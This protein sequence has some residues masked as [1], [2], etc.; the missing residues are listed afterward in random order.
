MAEAVR[1]GKRGARVNTISH[2]TI[3]TSLAKDE[4]TGPRGVGYRRMI[5]LCAAR[6]SGT[7][8]KVGI[9]GVLLMVSDGA[10]ITGSDFLM[11]GGATAAYWLDELAPQ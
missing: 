2:G 6:R 8:V 3:I 1:W 9:V 7:P 11:D 4:L 10:F 5:E